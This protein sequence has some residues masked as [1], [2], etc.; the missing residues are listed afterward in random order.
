MLG[1]PTTIFERTFATYGLRFDYYRPI[2]P[3]PLN[4]FEEMPCK[5]DPTEN[6]CSFEKYPTPS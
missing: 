1:L 4:E 5:L 3:F 6:P 2:V